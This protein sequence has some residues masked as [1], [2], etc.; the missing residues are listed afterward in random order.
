MMKLITCFLAATVLLIVLQNHLVASLSRNLQKI[1]LFQ[2]KQS[3]TIS[4]PTYCSY[5]SYLD[6]INVYSIPSHPR[7]MNWNMSSDYCTWE[8]VSCEHA[9][10]DVVGLD[11]SCSQLVGAILPNNTLFQ[12]S[13]LRFLNLSWNDFSLSNQFPQEFGFF[14]KGLSHL[15]LSNTQ[16]SGT[17]P[18]DISHL[19][20]LVSLDLSEL[21]VKLEYQ[22][23]RLLLQNLTQLSV[24]K[25][26]SVDISSVLPMNLFANLRVL[27]LGG[28]G[29]YGAL[30]EE[31][32]HLPNLEVLD[33]NNGN[34]NLNVILP[35]VKWGCSGSLQHLIFV[36]I[37]LSRGMPDSIALLES[38]A[39]LVL[40]N[41]NMSGSIP[42]SIGN[43][44]RLTK[45]DLSLNHLNSQIPNGLAY[46]NLRVLDLSYNNLS[47]LL[48]TSLFELTS[49][50]TLEIS[51]NGL[52]GQL[53]EFDSSKSQL[54]HFSCKNNLLYGQI[55]QLF[56]GLV[57]LSKLDLSS[58]NFSG[59]LDIEMF[60]PLKYLSTLSLS[61]N[62]IS[63]RST[64]MATLPPKLKYLYLS[65]CNMKDFSRVSK[66]A[67]N[68]KYVDLSYNQIDGVI[69]HWIGLVGR[70]SLSYLNLSH[71]SIQGGLEGLPWNV[72]NI[73]D[74]RSN[75]LNGSLPSLICNTSSLEILILSYNNLSGVLPICSTDVSRL[76][77][78]DV[79]MNNI[80]GS[81]PSNLTN[82]RYLNSIHLHGN[83]L[84]GR[85]PSS[86][87]KF[88]FLE[89]FDLGSN[90]ITDTFPQCLEALPNLQV[91][92]LKSNKF[93]GLINK[94]SSS[95][96]PFPS[97]RII[98]LSNNEFSGSLPA[99]YFK[100][101]NAMMDG[102]PYKIR[103]SYMGDDYYSESISLVIKGVEIEFLRIIN[104]LTT[105]DFSNNNFEG[106]IV[107]YIGNL[108]SL[109]FL[110]ISHNYL[111]GHIPS[112]IGKLSMLESLD[113][114]SNQLD[115]DIPQ[116]LTSLY[117]CAFL[118]LS[119]NLLRGR[120]PKGAQ[121]DTFENSSYAGN[122]ELCGH[123]LSRKC[124]NYDGTHE[125]KDE[126]DDYFLT[127]FT[128]EAVVIGYGCGVVPAFIIGYLMLLAG[129][130][131]FAGIIAKEL[132]LKI[133]RLDIRMR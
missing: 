61:Y 41:C 16:F 118:N 68:I 119:C 39:T 2:F 76:I 38:L 71:N 12:L 107:D 117:S 106:K 47:G 69:P 28:T 101:F 121:L 64:G 88:V 42:K 30:P 114:S 111:T 35:K 20:K 57:N 105:I 132:G 8:G 110:N 53:H 92:V 15:N 102:E 131:K 91:L 43:L 72:L 27:D 112:S 133:K 125:E 9:T 24:L 104:V 67:E 77:V 97:L 81:L 73:L 31:V 83:K 56:S 6:S 130:P 99:M 50:K 37:N 78:F 18:S 85:I 22:V 33:I 94:S 96:H 44:R 29:L 19:Y 116:Q 82:F 60:S 34:I 80:Q 122:S 13:H 3:L 95:D 66:D 36:G 11:L 120:I 26:R 108:V 89:V 59:I 14:A 4:A 127:G 123:P 100:N 7:T 49:L 90:Q 21:R 32:F 126:D 58:N 128:W 46:T 5:Y 10:G 74:L 62:N 55:P 103:P 1:A 113:L 87:A 129:K 75:L 40:C 109:R 86:F 45:L 17:V 63:L 70:D 48:P 98:D 23:F 52:K 54:E 124:D 51:C 25:L 84:E 93:Y 115:G 65:S 79:R